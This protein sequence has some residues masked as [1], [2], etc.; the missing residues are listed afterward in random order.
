MIIAIIIATSAFAF[1]NRIGH[2]Q[3]G[4]ETD[5]AV[6]LSY[7]ET[8]IGFSP[9]QLEGGEELLIDSGRGIV[10]VSGAAGLVLAGDL[11]TKI[12]DISD[13]LVLTGDIDLVPGHMYI[14]IAL[15]NSV[16]AITLQAW[17]SS[18]IAIPGGTG[19]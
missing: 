4:S 9:V 16:T 17:Q 5:P 10:L 3:P 19:R 1:L 7:L 6:S 14:P 12:I 2:A 15:D 11:R 8:A 18:I 13:G